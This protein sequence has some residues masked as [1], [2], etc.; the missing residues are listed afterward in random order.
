MSRGTTRRFRIYTFDEQGNAGYVTIPA[1]PSYLEDTIYGLSVE[2]GPRQIAF[3]AHASIVKRKSY[4]D[5]YA[6]CTATGQLDC[7]TLF[8]TFATNNVSRLHDLIVTASGSISSQ[9][10]KPTVM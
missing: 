9:A 6:R 10:R 7:A 4:S 5:S 3:G 2:A 1:R 8:P